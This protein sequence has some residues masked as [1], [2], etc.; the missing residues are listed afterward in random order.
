MLHLGGVELVLPLVDQAEVPRQ[1]ALVVLA[2]H[3]VA[4]RPGRRGVMVTWL[5]YTVGHLLAGPLL[6]PLFKELP[7][8]LP[9]LLLVTGC[10]GL[11]PHQPPSCCY[12][13]QQSCNI[14]NL[15]DAR[16]NISLSL[17][18]PCCYWPSVVVT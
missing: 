16:K 3:H 11:P 6:V 14:F 7:N 8:G 4:A 15:T 12:L 5:H 17:Y 18:L 13:A 2:A 10:R 1:P 9:G